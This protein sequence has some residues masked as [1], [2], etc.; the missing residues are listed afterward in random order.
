MLRHMRETAFFG[1]LAWTLAGLSDVVINEVCYKNDAF[2]DGTGTLTSDWVELYN[3]G[4]EAVNLEGYVLGKKKS[5]ASCGAQICVLPSYELGP[6]EFFVV[7]FDKNLPPATTIVKMTVNGVEKDVPWIRSDA[8][9]LGTSTIGTTLVQDDVRLFDN[10]KVHT[11]LSNYKGEEI[12]ALIEG[13]GDD[14]T[15]EENTSYGSLWDGNIDDRGR[16][17]EEGYVIFASPTPW[18]S[19]ATGFTM[20][21][22]TLSQAPGVYA[23][24]PQVTVTSA[25][26]RAETLY[27]T[28]DGTDPRS[29]PTR[30]TLASGSFVTVDAR[31]NATSASGAFQT[32]AWIRTSPP[33]LEARVP[34]GDWQAPIGSVPRL[35]L[36]RRK[37]LL[38]LYRRSPHRRPLR[39]QPANPR[40]L[41]QRNR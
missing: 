11:R 17:A 15:L 16:P 21:P 28:L 7:Y 26:A 29:S 5:Y 1:V 9:S 33:E 6:H 8:F 38:L 20:A 22:P 23:A 34:G 30:R 10:T 13:D 41:R 40:A 25:D 31:A 39:K 12:A 35:P 3:A 14:K 32:N 4:D 37:H 27:Y 24:A 36:L 2:D 19:N 18:A